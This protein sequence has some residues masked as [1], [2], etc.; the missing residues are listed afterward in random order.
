MFKM[1]DLFIELKS[2]KKPYPFPSKDTSLKSRALNPFDIL[3]RI[4]WVE[5]FTFLLSA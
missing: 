4:T 1:L 3:P 5:K 2:T